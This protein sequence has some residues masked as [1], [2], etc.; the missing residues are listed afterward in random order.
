VLTLVLAVVAIALPDS[1]NPS[2][3]AAELVVAGGPRPGP[4][5]LVF[6]CAAWAVTFAFGVALAL[7]LGDLISSLV[8]HPSHTVK[9][10]LLTA[11]GIVVAAGGVAVWIR[12]RALAGHA[13]QAG[14]GAL[15][16]RAP[17]LLGAGVAGVELFSAFPYFAAIALVVGARIAIAAKVL[18]LALYCLVYTLPL[19]AFAVM[20]LAVGERAEAL[21]RPPIDWLFARWPLV[22][23]P[24]AACLGTGLAVYGAVRLSSI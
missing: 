17:A 21:L 13:P 9:Y 3:I 16:H 7:G 11:A 4:R 15:S 10:S 24:L 12:R 23:A 5:A 18:L 22:V 1:I 2:L 20:C 6:S 14:S 8:P 19:F